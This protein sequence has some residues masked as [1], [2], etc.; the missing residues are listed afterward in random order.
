MKYFFKETK[1]LPG[2]FLMVYFFMACHRIA[3]YRPSHFLLSSQISVVLFC[4]QVTNRQSYTLMQSHWPSCRGKIDGS[5]TLTISQDV[6]RIATEETAGSTPR[7][8]R[9]QIPK[10]LFILLKASHTVFRSLRRSWTTF[11][12]LLVSFRISMLCV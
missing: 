11:S 12:I 6:A 8:H 4:L 9:Y 7:C 2:K 5:K 3:G 10:Y 1:A